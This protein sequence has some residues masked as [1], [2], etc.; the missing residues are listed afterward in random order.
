MV[1]SLLGEI[2][3]NLGFE[4]RAIV[5]LCQDVQSIAEI[6][7][8]LE[9]PLG[10]MRALVG[11]LADEGLVKLYGPARNGDQSDLALLQRVLDGLH[12]I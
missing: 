12:R 7:A 1:T 8:R 11:D 2:A 9:V 5:R 4:R 3:T 6:S 10:V